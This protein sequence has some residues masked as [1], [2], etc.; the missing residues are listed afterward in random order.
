MRTGRRSQQDQAL[1]LEVGGP[2]EGV[3]KDERREGWRL[4]SAYRTC[5]FCLDFSL[6]ESVVP[7]GEEQAVMGARG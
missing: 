4:S 7:V 5:S 3:E 2:E 6:P 1:Y